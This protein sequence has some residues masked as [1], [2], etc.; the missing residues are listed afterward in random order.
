MDEL[1]SRKFSLDQ[2][3]EAMADAEEGESLR[4]VIMF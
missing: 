1:I 4:N 3:N 2:I